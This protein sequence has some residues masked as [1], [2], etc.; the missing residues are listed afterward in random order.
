MNYVYKYEY[1]RRPVVF[2]CIVFVSFVSHCLVIID[3]YINTN[4]NINSITSC[5]I[6]IDINTYII[7]ILNDNNLY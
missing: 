3:S 5:S 2:V 4:I 1:P 7:I 6:D